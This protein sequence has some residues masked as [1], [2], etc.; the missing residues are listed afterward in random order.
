MFNSFPKSLLIEEASS[1]EEASWLQNAHQPESNTVRQ[2]SYSFH[3]NLSF[4]D[5]VEAIT[6]CLSALDRYNFRF[7]LSDDG[8]LLRHLVDNWSETIIHDRGDFFEPSQKWDLR[9]ESPIKIQVLADADKKNMFHIYIWVHGIL[10]ENDI[11][12]NFIDEL[13]QI[14]KLKEIQNEDKARE[15]P[16]TQVPDFTNIVL[17]EFRNTLGIPEMTPTDNFF[18]YGGHSL[19]AIRIIASLKDK[20]GIKLSFNQFFKA[21]TA[22]GLSTFVTFMEAVEETTRINAADRDSAPLTLA[23]EFLWSAYKS[24]NWSSIYNLPF[25]VRLE[26][27]INEAVFKQA[28]TDIL[29]RHQGLRTLF[30]T[31]GLGGVVQQITPMSDLSDF[32]WFWHSEQSHGVLLDD[33][34]N[35]Q[36][37]LSK[38]LPIRIRFIDD[39]KH[40]KQILSFLVH[41]MVI[42]EWSLNTIMNDLRIAYKSRLE[43]K[44]SE[45]DEP[46]Y[47]IVD[48]ALFQKENNLSSTHRTYW[49]NQLEGAPYG[50]NVSDPNPIENG[51]LLSTEA[52]SISVIFGHEIYEKL[53]VLAKKHNGSVF[54]MLYAA[55][56]LSLFKA[57]HKQDL[58]IGTSASGRMEEKYMNAVGYFTTMVAHRMPFE[59]QK[60][61]SEFLRLVS[62]VI[63]DSMQYADVPIDIIQSDLGL[64]ERSALIFDVYIHIHSKNALNGYL[65]DSSNNKIHYKQ[66]PPLKDISMFGLHY[67]VMDNVDTN[68]D[69]ELTLLL[70][71]QTSRFS[72]ELAKLLIADAHEN[73][74]NLSEQSQL[75]RPIRDWM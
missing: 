51:N 25:A 13:F 63:G 43:N 39:P 8:V 41:H 42:D 26:E 49:K 32:Q 7:Q 12:E 23:Q 14:L 40:R 10:I 45:W 20:Y 21:P 5:V 48:Y 9:N 19:L 55:I 62:G 24:F 54:T 4:R 37:D 47:S 3:T 61:V 44:E 67:E 6:E 58:V 65:I 75:G 66:I 28:F 38:E 31:D 11:Q 27:H 68:G 64:S 15:L 71:Y 17:G 70:T 53:L 36:F 30:K 50:L 74:V 59:Q 22:E 46:A 69:H 35:Y 60:S 57:G 1:H 72:T 73:I 2:S 18:D 56:V 34:A 52:K 29:Q 16:T 33:E